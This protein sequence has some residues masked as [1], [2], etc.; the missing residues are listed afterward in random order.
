MASSPATAGGVD[1]PAGPVLNTGRYVH[2]TLPVSM[3]MANRPPLP[4]WLPARIV[5]PATV[6]GLQSLKPGFT[7]SV[8]TGW[9]RTGWIRAGSGCAS[10]GTA[11]STA[12]MIVLPAK[13]L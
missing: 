9:L 3:L 11:H 2:F 6:A 1:R 12:I 13:H 5:V 4:V 8:S 10:P 7:V